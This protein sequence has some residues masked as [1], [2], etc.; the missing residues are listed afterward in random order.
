MQ[1]EIFS[2]FT[3]PRGS[4]LVRG[5]PSYSLNLVIGCLN[6]SQPQKV[7]AVGKILI[8]HNVYDLYYSYWQPVQ[9]AR[10]KVVRKD[11]R[12]GCTT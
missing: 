11:Y 1:S 9:S 5:P 3:S 12:L 6:L 2:H 10:I 4:L 8:I 7:V